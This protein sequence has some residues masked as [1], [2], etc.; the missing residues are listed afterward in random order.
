MVPSGDVGLLMDSLTRVNRGQNHDP[1]WRK[2]KWLIVNN[3]PKLSW[4][5]CCFCAAGMQPGEHVV[6][7]HEGFAVQRVQLYIYKSSLKHRRR[8]VN[9]PNYASLCCS[10]YDFRS[11]RPKLTLVRQHKQPLLIFKC[12][13]IGL[14]HND[15]CAVESEQSHFSWL[16]PEVLYNM[17]GVAVK[18][19]K[20]LRIAAGQLHDG[21][22]FWHWSL[23]LKWFRCYLKW[24]LDPH[25]VCSCVIF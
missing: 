20:L 2:I 5:G 1:S 15:Y 10:G 3:I 4:H 12:T 25:A 9:W 8:R 18:M 21:L 13:H 22:R 23:V 24:G 16:E 19:T 6:G 11:A 17:V 14:V 7:G